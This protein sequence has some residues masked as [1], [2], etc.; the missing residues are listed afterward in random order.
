MKPLR[1]KTRVADAVEG[2]NGSNHVTYHV[3]EEID[4]VEI[5][6]HAKCQ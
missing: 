4:E 3:D 1:F 6:V 2:E 5:I